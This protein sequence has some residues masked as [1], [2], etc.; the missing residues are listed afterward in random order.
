MPR[1]STVK[2]GRPAAGR[3]PAGAALL[4][5]LA[6]SAA[7]GLCLITG[8]ARCGKSALLGLAGAA[9]HPSRHRTEHTVQ[10]YAPLAGQSAH[11]AV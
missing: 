3:E 4:G 2:W 6:D 5:W 8:G 9:R 10:S 1:V 11:G 7:P